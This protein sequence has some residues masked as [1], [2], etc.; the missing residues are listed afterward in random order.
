MTDR[1]KTGD[2]VVLRYVETTASVPMVH[3]VMGDPAGTGGGQP[4]LVGGEVVTV[5]A[6]PYRVIKDT[7]AELVL[8]GPEGTA[9]P[10]WHIAEQHYLEGTA[11]S[12]GETI[13][14]LYTDRS[15]DITLFFETASQAPWFYEALFNSQG[16]QAGWRDK[17]DQFVAAAQTAERKP[18]RFRGW[19][20]NVQTPFRRMP[21]GVDI[22]T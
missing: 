11:L 7:G 5:Q 6:R 22:T 18:G 12:R 14:I 2:V 17:R 4:F 15:Y 13:R 8:F 3:A 10:R 9:L 1:W 19:Y 21:F 20:V 16:L